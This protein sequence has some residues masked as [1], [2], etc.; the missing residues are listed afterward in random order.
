MH[1]AVF[2][3]RYEITDFVGLVKYLKACGVDPNVFKMYVTSEES[4]DVDALDKLSDQGKIGVNNIAGCYFVKCQKPYFTVT[5]KRGK[6]N[7]E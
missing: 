3:K 6:G 5:V 1:K 4:V 7:G 2:K